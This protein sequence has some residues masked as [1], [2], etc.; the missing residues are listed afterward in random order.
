MDVRPWPVLP[1]ED[2][3]LA[4]TM[5]RRLRDSTQSAEQLRSRAH[6][7]RAGQATPPGFR[8]SGYCGQRGPLRVLSDILPPAS[9]AE[10]FDLR[11]VGSILRIP[12]FMRD[13]LQ[14]PWM[15]MPM[16]VKGELCVG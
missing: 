16:K 6:E 7:L 1:D 9:R 13:Y 11:S 12:V 8:L 10:W 3:W 5:D 15:R 14:L 4:D 2:R